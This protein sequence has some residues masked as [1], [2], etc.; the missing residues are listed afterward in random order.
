[1]DQAR[2]QLAALGAFYYVHKGRGIRMAKNEDKSLRPIL[3]DIEE[4]F[5]QYFEIQDWQGFRII[6][7]VAAAHYLHGEMLWFRIVGASG[8]GKTELLRGI[9]ESPST[10]TMETVTPAAIRGGLKDGARLLDRINGS[11]VITKDLAPM[12]SSRS[13]V[14]KELFGLIRS[15]ADGFLD[16]DFGTT[17][18]Y[19]HQKVH[20]DWMLATTPIIEVHKQLEGMLG[21]RFVDLR[22]R[23]GN[24]IRMARQALTNNPQMPTIRLELANQVRSL[25]EEAQKTAR[26]NPPQLQDNEIE[27]IAKIA[28]AV[29]LCRSP[30]S[31][32]SYSKRLQS[33]PMPEVGTRLAQSF[34]RIALGLKLLGIVKWEPYIKRLAWDSIPS[35]RVAILKE[36]KIKDQTIKY[37]QR[38]TEFPRSTLYRQLTHLKLLKVVGSTSEFSVDEDNEELDGYTTIS[39]KV[40][41]PKYPKE[42]ANGD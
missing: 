22:W 7:G 26:L 13:D 40:K 10:T 14:R 31:E 4:N 21:E 37:L 16:S 15:V 1:M 39:L 5:S 42:M 25:M 2:I 3:R 33:I 30:V 36:L 17:E 29:A 34:S 8:A 9:L 32:D 38:E 12:T 19:I 28:D 41:L 35:I 11:L 23:P 6:L 20:F 18:G 24:R 27:K